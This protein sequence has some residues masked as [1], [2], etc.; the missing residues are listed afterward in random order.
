MLILFS[1][2][3]LTDPCCPPRFSAS[4]SLP[5]QEAQAMQ[6]K[7]SAQYKNEI[8]MAK[9]QR[10]YELKKAAYDIEV[11]TKKAESEM[12]YQLQVQQS[13]QEIMLLF[14]QW[15]GSLQSEVW[16][17]LC[18]Q[19]PCTACDEVLT[20]VGHPSISLP[21]CE[22]EATHWGGEDAGPGGWAYAAN[23]AAG[24]G[25][26][27]QGEGAGGQGEETCRRWA[28]PPGETGWGSAVSHEDLDALKL[29]V[30]NYGGGVVSR[31]VFS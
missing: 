6:V 11:N 3:I 28:V 4:L 7:V 9:A 27:P 1:R 18:A 20:S 24:A 30:Q 5:L 16:V 15:A 13:E 10:D 12:A 23:H 17:R 19:L 21:G 14:D 31:Q 8:D 2:V 29:L 22:D 25:D 26:H